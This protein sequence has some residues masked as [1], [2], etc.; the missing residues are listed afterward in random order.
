MKTY[1]L[2]DTNNC[3]VRAFHGNRGP[4]SNWDRIGM[5]LNIV[6]CQLALAVDK[7][8]PDHVIFFME[9]KS[10]R[11]TIYP[12]YKNARKLKRAKSTP[13]EQE[14]MDGLFE[15]ISDF[16]DFVST[17]TNAT[18]LRAP[19]CEADDLIARWTQKHP[20]DINII[21][22]NDSDFNQ[23]LSNSVYI[24]HP[25][26]NYLLTIAGAYTTDG[27]PYT[28][29]N[30]PIIDPKYELFYKCIRGDA[31]DSIMSAYPGVREKGTKNKIGI[32]Q[33]YADMEYKGYDWQNFMLTEILIPGTETITTV[34]ERYALN[35]QLIDLTKQPLHIKKEMDDLIDNVVSK[36]IQSI[37]MHFIRFA[38]NYQINN[39]R[40]N[41]MY[42]LNIFTKP[43][44]SERSSY[45][46]EKQTGN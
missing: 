30:I 21:F 12:T 38:N 34:A 41:P 35:E 45:G 7:L 15:A 43:Y 18:V 22:S 14:A 25:T 32:L 31:S 23:L 29:K 3:F 33:A 19:N 5:T 44:I 37:G 20:N 8:K 6:L 1:L 46:S 13:E 24:L 10:W 42:Y 9:G 17:R 39:I 26:H 36:Q 16:T 11:S 2:I 40:D 27:M 4:M 28:E